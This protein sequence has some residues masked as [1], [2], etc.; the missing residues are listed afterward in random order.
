MKKTLLM[1]AGFALVLA[2]ASAC[3]S[4]SAKTDPNAPKPTNTVSGAEPAR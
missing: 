4:P 2:A 3:F 1:L